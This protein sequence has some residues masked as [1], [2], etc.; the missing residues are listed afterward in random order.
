MPKITK[1]EIFQIIQYFLTWK[2]LRIDQILN[3]I[4]KVIAIELCNYLQQILNNSVIL[5]YLFLYLR[6]SI[7]IN[8]YKYIGNK[9]YINLKSYKLIS[10]F[11]T[12]D[13]IMKAILVIKISY[14]II[15]Y[16]PLSMTY[17]HS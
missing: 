4:L 15:I 16:I 3:E 6:E 9:N 14:M 1:N 17:F 10:L 2:T 5:I 8:L 7:I 12:I 11:M 13:K